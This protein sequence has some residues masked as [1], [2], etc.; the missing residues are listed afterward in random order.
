M[1]KIMNLPTQYEWLNSVKGL[2]KNI[3]LALKEFGVAEIVGKGSNATI[4]A[5]RDEL[6]QAGAKISGYSD[7]DIPWCGLFA[8]IVT[9]RRMKVAP[10]VVKDP[11]WARNWAKYGDKSPQASLGDVLVFV[12]NGGGHVAFYVGEDAT[13]YHCLGGNQSNK[14]CFTRIAISRCIAVRRPPY[15]TTPK[16]VKPYRLAPTG[17]PSKNEA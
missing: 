16:G 2:P 10:E 5:W 6:N 7:D 1:S 9:L 12:R 3:A 8:A 11:L 17:K 4:M 13:H 15:V 14:V